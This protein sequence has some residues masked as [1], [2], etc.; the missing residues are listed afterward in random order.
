MMFGLLF[1]RLIG[2]VLKVRSSSVR[3]L[4]WFK[5]EKVC[6]ER[7]FVIGFVCVLV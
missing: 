5:V 6:E 3:N 1:M 7:V 2:F 4:V